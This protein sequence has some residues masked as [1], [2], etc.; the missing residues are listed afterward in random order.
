MRLC[1][2]GHEEVCYEERSCPA[3]KLIDEIEEKNAEIDSLNN[4]ISAY[5]KE[6]LVY[7]KESEREKED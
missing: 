5:E 6:I 3:C 2:E 7:Q 1:S 4:D